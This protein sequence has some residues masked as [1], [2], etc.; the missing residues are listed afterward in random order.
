MLREWSWINSI[1]LFGLVDILR[2]RRNNRHSNP[3]L[4]V[5]VACGNGD[6]PRSTDSNQRA[7]L[8]LPDAGS[9]D[10]LWLNEFAYPSSELYYHQPW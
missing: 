7:S 5:L 10:R 8:R 6:S 3:L 9:E 4:W 1:H 2:C